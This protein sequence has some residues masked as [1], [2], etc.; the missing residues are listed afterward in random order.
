MPVV[1]NSAR[2]E[3]LYSSEVTSDSLAYEIAR[4]KEENA[5][6]KVEIEA[7]IKAFRILAR[8]EPDSKEPTP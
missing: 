1:Y 3:M 7:W 4:L 2:G 5:A 8:R 6:L